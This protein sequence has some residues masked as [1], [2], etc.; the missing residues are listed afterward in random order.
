MQA[1]AHCTQLME[2]RRLGPAGA[3][4]PRP[5]PQIN[6]LTSP[7]QLKGER[8]TTKKKE[9]KKKERER[10]R[11]SFLYIHSKFYSPYSTE[12]GSRAQRSQ[13]ERE[14]G[15]RKEN[16][17]K[18]GT[19]GRGGKSPCQGTEGPLD[20]GSWGPASLG[21]WTASRRH[22]KRDSAKSCPTRQVTQ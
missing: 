12:T 18:G 11:T 5:S 21:P 19:S 3:P 15:R 16:K 9:R 22:R 8:N 4:C 6:A 2:T 1:A 10:K 13:A 20:V 17:E 14:T 7:G